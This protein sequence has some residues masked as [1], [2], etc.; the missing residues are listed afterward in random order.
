MIKKQIEADI[1]EAHRSRWSEGATD[2]VKEIE[3]DIIEAH[4]SIWSEGARVEEI[5]ADRVK[6]MLRWQRRHL[7]W[8]SAL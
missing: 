4:R 2:R 7:V 5:E 8:R 1:I 6:E 3:A